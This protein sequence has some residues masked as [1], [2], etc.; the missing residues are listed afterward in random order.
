MRIYRFITSFSEEESNI[1]FE[2]LN[3]TTQK[4]L[5]KL[6]P[7]LVIQSD[8]YD[9]KYDGKVCHWRDGHM[10]LSIG[11]CTEE[12][13]SEFKKYDDIIHEGMSGFTTI[14]DITDE[15][16]YGKHNME[17]YGFLKESVIITFDNYIENNI[18]KDIILDK[19]NLYGIDS[20]SDNDKRVLNDKT[21]IRYV[22]TII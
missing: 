9:V 16:L 18:T 17:I 12:Y 7:E 4:M 22:D 19:I 20:L 3:E 14:E 6:I 15:V 21:Y 11:L 5:N 1:G 2:R 8:L 10:G 13:A